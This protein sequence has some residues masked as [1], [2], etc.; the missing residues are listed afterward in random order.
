VNSGN[1]ARD[2]KTIVAGL[3]AAAV[4]GACSSGQAAAPSPTI[5]VPRAAATA[6][7][8]DAA[9]PPPEL[10]APPNYVEMRVV[11]VRPE[12]NGGAV[13]LDDA[14][15][16][17][18]I[19]IFVGGTE[20]L[21]IELRR[22]HEAFKRPLTHDLLESV[23]HKLDGEL[24]KVQIDELRDN[25]FIG[26]IFVRRASQTLRIDA[27]PSDAIALALGAEVPIYVARKVIEQA[28]VPPE[29]TDEP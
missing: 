24:V 1:R 15:H 25:T 10:H 9:A 14:N 11:S 2:K 8:I 6:L 21:S 13:V 4:V 16:R 18:A 19:R 29:P 28:G 3:L 22:R 5:S 26:S 23:M 20:L 17:V 7:P 27:R 12:P